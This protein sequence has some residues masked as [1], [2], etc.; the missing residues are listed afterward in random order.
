[1]NK[2][3]RHSLYTDKNFENTLCKIVSCANVVVAYNIDVIGM[4]AF[5]AND[6]VNKISYITLIVTDIEYQNKGIATELFNICEYYAKSKGMKS[7]NLEVWKDNL[8]AIAFYKNK[9]M[10]FLEKKSESSY[11]MA[12]LLY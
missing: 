2:F 5:Y 4:V 11:F 6:Y 1:M 3:F 10:H 12:K 8:N 9:G 7:L